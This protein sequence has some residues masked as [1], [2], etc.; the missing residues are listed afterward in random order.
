MEMR[1]TA[2]LPL[3]HAWSIAGKNS[4]GGFWGV[5][6]PG[7]EIMRKMGALRRKYDEKTDLCTKHEDD[8][9]EM[10]KKRQMNILMYA[11]KDELRS[12]TSRAQRLLETHGL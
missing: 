9:D 4:K 7:Q 12:G 8:D 2:D 3:V 11:H 5:K 1:E 6:A 10:K